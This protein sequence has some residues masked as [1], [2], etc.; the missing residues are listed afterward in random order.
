MSNTFI[1]TAIVS[2]ADLFGGDYHKVAFN[3]STN[4]VQ[5]YQ[6]YLI[7]KGY[8]VLSVKSEVAAYSD[9]LFSDRQGNMRV[10]D[11]K[12]VLVEDSHDTTDEGLSTDSSSS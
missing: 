1:T 12:L 4:D 10:V 7:E 11:N 3:T 2:R 9:E 6:G 5:I 8:N